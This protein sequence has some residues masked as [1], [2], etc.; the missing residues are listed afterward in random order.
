MPGSRAIGRW[1]G[2]RPWGAGARQTPPHTTGK[3]TDK[4]KGKDADKDANRV[5]GINQPGAIPGFQQYWAAQR[6][7]GAPAQVTAESVDRD[8]LVEVLQE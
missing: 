6:R 5:P 3:A 8:A 2:W 1:T 4:D 7:K